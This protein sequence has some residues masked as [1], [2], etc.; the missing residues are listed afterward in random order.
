MKESIFT[1]LSVLV[2]GASGAKNEN[3]PEKVLSDFGDVDSSVS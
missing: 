1:G 3:S 2:E